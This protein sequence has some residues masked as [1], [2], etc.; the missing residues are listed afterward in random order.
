MILVPLQ[1][2]L[3]SVG[4]LGKF[5]DAKGFKKLPKVQ[6]I[7]KSG[8]TVCDSH[9]IFRCHRFHRAIKKKYINIFDHILFPNLI[10][11]QNNF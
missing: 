9:K 2:L 10:V 3:K 7:A 5:I 1:K 4:D 8:H 6:K 11:T